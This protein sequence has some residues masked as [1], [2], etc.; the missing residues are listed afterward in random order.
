[1]FNWL[2]KAFGT[3]KRVL[4]RVKSGIESGAKIFSKGKEMYSQAKNF[5]S[6]LPVVGSM[7]KEIIGNAEN[8]V[9]KEAKQRLGADFNDLNKVVSTAE[10]VSRYLPRG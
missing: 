5:A 8:Y 7:A 3:T 4:G 9:N 10:N 6:N 2:K 1:M